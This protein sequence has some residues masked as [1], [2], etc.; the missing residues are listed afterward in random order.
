MLWFSR[1]SSAG[2][3]KKLRK[4]ILIELCVWVDSWSKVEVINSDADPNSFVDPG[5]LSRILYH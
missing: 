4:R 2:L 3:V 5:S 1:F